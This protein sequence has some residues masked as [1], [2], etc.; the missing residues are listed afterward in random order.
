VECTNDS[1]K[2][3]LVGDGGGEGVLVDPLFK[4][5]ADIIAEPV[6]AEDRKQVEGRR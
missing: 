1:L 5:A 6:F 2:S 4:L 3:K